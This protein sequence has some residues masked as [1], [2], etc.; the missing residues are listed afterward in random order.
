MIFADDTQ[1]YYH[2]YSR[3]FDLETLPRVVIDDNSLPYVTEARS[4]GVTLTNT[5]K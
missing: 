5:L 2:F 1:L 4:L 3:E